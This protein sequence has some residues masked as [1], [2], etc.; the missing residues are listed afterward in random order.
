MYVSKLPCLSCC[1][2]PFSAPIHGDMQF[3]QEVARNAL[4]RGR[5][6]RA[7]EPSVYSQLADPFMEYVPLSPS[8]T[9]TCSAVPLVTTRSPAIQNALY[10]VYQRHPSCLL[11]NSSLF[12]GIPQEWTNTPRPFPCIVN[13]ILRSLRPNFHFRSLTVISLGDYCLPN[14]DA[15]LTSVSPLGMAPLHLSSQWAI[16]WMVCHVQCSKDQKK[17][18]PPRR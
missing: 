14:T 4:L 7:P 18:W 8:T 13:L 10:C 5:P 9:S 1:L 16:L 11:L 3:I 17:K 6:Y 15:K 12:Q 2:T